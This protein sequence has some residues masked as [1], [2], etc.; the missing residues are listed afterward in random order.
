[1]QANPV[2]AISNGARGAILSWTDNRS[3]TQA[4]AEKL[5][6][7]G[8]AA[9][10]DTDGVQLCATTDGQN[11]SAMV[12]DGAGGAIVDWTDGRN[13]LGGG[14]FDIY[15]Q[16]VNS[17]GVVQ[18]A[19]NGDSLCTSPVDKFAS[20]MV[21]DAAGGALVGW[22]SSGGIYA[23]RVSSN[24]GL[25]TAA[26]APST[27]QVAPALAWPNPFNRQVTIAFSLQRAT[28]VRM[29]VF[30]VAGRRVWASASQLMQPGRRDIA[31]DGRADDG[32]PEGGG[33]YFLR[34]RGPGIEAS[35]A[36]VR[37]K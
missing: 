33:I 32:A 23:G 31:W 21:P 14:G 35:R 5:D 16:R 10:G 8:V 17:S 18:W 2:V 6:S 20:F 25:I 12:S 37:V 3:G 36:V 1:V 24:G 28:T 27:E 15:A 29:E 11:L 26:P 13:R 30:D 9:W 19:P 22:T 34:V 4:F 7:L